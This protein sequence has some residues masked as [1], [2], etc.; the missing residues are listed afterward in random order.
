VTSSLLLTGGGPGG[1]A[2]QA[3]PPS[4]PAPDVWLKADNY[5]AGTGVWTDAG[6]LGFSPSQTPG[7]TAPTAVADSGFKGRPCVRYSD[8]QN[9]TGSS[10]PLANSRAKGTLMIAFRSRDTSPAGGS[11]F[12]TTQDQIAWLSDGRASLNSADGDYGRLSAGA[13]A[14]MLSLSGGQLATAVYDGTQA[15]NALKLRVWRNL[16]EETL[17][18]TAGF[19][20]DAALP[21]TTF[22]GGSG[23]FL[24]REAGGSGW[25][26]D[27]MEILFWRAAALTAGERQ[28]WENYLAAK[29]FTKATKYLVVS[30]DSNGVG[31]PNNTANPWPLR[32]QTALGWSGLTNSS[33]VGYKLSQGSASP[34]F[35]VRDDWHAAQP[36]VVALGT[37]DLAVDHADLATLQGLFNALKTKLTAARYPIFAFTIP[38][39]GSNITGADETTRAA[40]NAW[41]AVQT[42]I[43]VI[44]VAAALG[45]PTGAGDANFEGDDLHMTDAGH[46]VVKTAV[47][48]AFAAAG[49]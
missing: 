41:L 49:Y 48:A 20:A 28:A 25:P 8:T 39:A 18:Y 33:T 24:G 43:T 35:T 45:D 2:G 40:Y 17:T 37:N 3:T 11:V 36:Y 13:T 30:G 19:V 21:A 7:A 47:L 46:E 4:S 15:S 23:V 29:Y 5:S 44:D 10:M 34:Q 32:V 38:A 27:A 31:S 42:G 26:Q 6:T 22:A 12:S 16:V 14:G 9:L 1:G